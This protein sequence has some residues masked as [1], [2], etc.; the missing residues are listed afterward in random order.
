MN[1]SLFVGPYITGLGACIPNVYLLSHRYTPSTLEPK[2]P[3]MGAFAIGT[4]YWGVKYEGVI[5]EC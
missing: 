1:N 2:T 3:A 5:R 4:G